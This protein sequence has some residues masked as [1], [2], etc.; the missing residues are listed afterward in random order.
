[1]KK[2]SS[3]KFEN[4][5]TLIKEFMID[6]STNNKTFKELLNIYCSCCKT[7]NPDLSNDLRINKYVDDMKNNK[8]SYNI[9]LTIENNL[10]NDGVHR[11]IAYLKCIKE[12]VSEKDLPKI[13][14][15]II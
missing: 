7:F 6:R 2:I 10:V 8:W 5:L 14:L 1:M 9:I 4:L 12:G 15:L 13:Y 11:G 3:H